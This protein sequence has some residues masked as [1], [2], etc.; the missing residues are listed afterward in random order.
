MIELKRSAYLYAQELDN[1]GDTHYLAFDA[2]TR[3]WNQMPMGDDRLTPLRLTLDTLSESGRCYMQS[4][5]LS[6]HAGFSG[7]ALVKL[8]PTTLDAAGRVSP[9][10]F[11]FNVFSDH[12]EQAIAGLPSQLGRMSRKLSP[13]VEAQLSILRSRLARPKVLFF[14]S[15]LFC[16]KGRVE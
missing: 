9:I 13:A 6:C 1:S 11:L 10:L 15:L 12:R 8:S 3:S 7:E 2:D 5:G 14:L 16:R 4:E